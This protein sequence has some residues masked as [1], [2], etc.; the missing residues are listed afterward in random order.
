M[1][2]KLGQATPGPARHALM[3]GEHRPDGPR[4]VCQVCGVLELLADGRGR[5]SRVCRQFRFL[6]MLLSWPL[7]P[8]TSAIAILNAIGLKVTLPAT[9]NSLPWEAVGAAVLV[10]ARFHFTVAIAW[11]IPA[12]GCFLIQLESGLARDECGAWMGVV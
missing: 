12:F 3:T 4:I 5:N 8:C 2:Q 7:A 1:Y 10:Q 9:P 11:T 6:I